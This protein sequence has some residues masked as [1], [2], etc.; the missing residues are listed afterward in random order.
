MADEQL[1]PSTSDK[2]DDE[3][4][5]LDILIVL[6]KHKKLVFGLP[7]AAAVLAGLITLLMSNIYTATARILPPQQNQAAATALLAQFGGVVTGLSP[8]SLGLKNPAE[9]YVGMLRSRTVADALIDRFKLRDLY[10][11]NTLV[12]TRKKLAELSDISAG[13]DGIISI[14]VDDKDPKRAAAIANA[15]VDQLDK[16]TQGLALTDAAQRRLFYGHQLKATKEEL[17]NAE[18]EL[19][20]TQEATGLIQPDEQGKAII[21]AIATLKAGV[22]QK[23]AE[24]AGMGSFATPQNPDYVQARE[25]LVSL[26]AQLADMQKK[27]NINLDGSVLVPTGNIP[28]AGLDYVRK[29]REV[30]YQQELFELLAKQY[31]LAKMDEAKD[32]AIIQVVDR[33]VAPDRKSKPRRV[34]IILLAGLFALFFAAFLAYLRDVYARAARDPVRAVRIKT[35]RQFLSFQKVNSNHGPKPRRKE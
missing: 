22:I 25:A 20:K 29:L 14:A 35:L 33:A 34:L 6:A 30:K 31:E 15:Y 7:L 26:K 28:Q 23:E 12:E 9:L 24:I 5:L 18:V 1:P 10:G 8:S 27:H 11:K 2:Q 21:T 17:A 13:R 3:I 19:R 4:S 16:L 32:A